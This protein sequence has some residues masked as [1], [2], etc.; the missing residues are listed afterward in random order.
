[1][2]RPHLNYRRLAAILIST[3]LLALLALAL[4]RT[5]L[6]APPIADRIYYIP[7]SIEGSLSV[8]F[9]VQGRYQIRNTGPIPHMQGVYKTFGEYIVF[10][11]AS[12]HCAWRPGIWK[13]SLDDGVLHMTEIKEKCACRFFDFLRPM[14]SVD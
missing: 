2:P 14:P 4:F 8:S 7:V 6:S 11:E 3:A 5:G 1:M 10:A 13:W 12:G 9:D